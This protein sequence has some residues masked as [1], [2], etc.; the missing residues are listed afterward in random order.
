MTKLLCLGDSIM[1]G[2]TG[3]DAAHPRANPTI[4]DKIGQL[5]GAQVDNKAISATSVAAGQNSMVDMLSKVNFADYDYILIGYGANDWG[6]QQETIA[7]LK[8]GLEMLASN[9]DVAG[10]NPYVLIDLPI[11]SFLHGNVGLDGKN[12]LGVTQ[13]QV[14]DTFKNFAIEHGYEYYDWRSNEPCTQ[15]NRKTTMGDGM[16]HP[17]NAVQQQMAQRLA[18]YIKQTAGNRPT[19]P[20]QPT[21]PTSPN[22][23]TQPTQPTSPSQPTN[24]DQP[25]QPTTPIKKQLSIPQLTDTFQ[26]G[27]NVSSGVNSTVDFI[28]SLYARI[29]DAY[30]M[31]DAPKI[32]WK[33][34]LGNELLRVLRNGVITSLMELNGHINDLIRYCKKQGIMNYE[35]GEYMATIDLGI[36]RML[37]A[38]EDYQAIINDDWKL[39]QNTLNQLSL[40]VQEM[41]G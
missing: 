21:Q 30:G 18:D 28:N 12:E 23:P 10:N 20:T 19:K 34:S 17:T 41:E 24:P 5:I 29:A 36:P 22:Q 8:N 1:W 25:T 35:T 32:D 4:P 6:L 3:F 7:Q 15:E 38:D 9:I 2:V 37:T 40:Y 31:P 33:I 11:E 13:N 14:C 16:L 39:I 27:A 26:I